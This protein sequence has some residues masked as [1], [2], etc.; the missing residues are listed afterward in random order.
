[1]QCADCADVAEDKT[2]IQSHSAGRTAA[3][4]AMESVAL[5]LEAKPIQRELRERLAE[6]QSRIAAEAEAVALNARGSEAR[7]GHVL[8]VIR[9]RNGMAQNSAAGTVQEVTA[10]GKAAADKVFAA[11]EDMYWRVG[12]GDRL[13]A[14]AEALGTGSSLGLETD[15]VPLEAGETQTGVAGAQASLTPFQTA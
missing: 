4:L 5:Q 10:V 9:L 14:E 3:V 7:S 8:A 15:K 1:M 13:V 6:V 11:V 2:G 12:A